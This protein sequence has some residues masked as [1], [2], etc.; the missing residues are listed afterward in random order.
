VES[1]NTDFNL[2]SCILRHPKVSITSR[3]LRIELIHVTVDL[4]TDGK[5]ILAHDIK[6]STSAGID[7]QGDVHLLTIRTSIFATP[8]GCACLDCNQHLDKLEEL[9]GHLAAECDRL[10]AQLDER[11]VAS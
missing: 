7:T 8:R 3:D 4:R 1:V 6:N 9:C 5:L 10:R 11:E 2:E